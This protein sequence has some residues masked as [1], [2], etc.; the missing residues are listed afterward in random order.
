MSSNRVGY[1]ETNE[2]KFM[3]D[4]MDQNLREHIQR[5]TEERDTLLRTGVYSNSDAIIVELDKR[6]RDCLKEAKQMQQQQSWLAD[7]FCN[8][9]YIY[10]FVCLFLLNMFIYKRALY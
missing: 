4:E 10:V 5:L 2:V 8:N 3:D 1:A 7:L 6:I 9:F